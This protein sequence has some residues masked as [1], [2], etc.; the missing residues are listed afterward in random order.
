[1]FFV[2]LVLQLFLFVLPV[3]FLIQL[4]Q[5]LVVII[6]PVKQQFIE[7]SIVVIFIVEVNVL[8]QLAQRVE[9]VIEPELQLI[10]IEQII[11]KLV[12]ELCVKFIELQIE[13]IEFFI[14]EFYEFFE[15]DI[16]RY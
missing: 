2:V 4:L 7:L 13:F 16:V 3:I 11:F 15:P 6:M 1:M 10:V 8:K 5:K 12:I 9:F 14:I